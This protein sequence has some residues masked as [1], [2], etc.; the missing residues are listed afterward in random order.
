MNQFTGTSCS[1]TQL[2]YYF[3]NELVLRNVRVKNIFVKL[4]EHKYTL[5][6]IG[7]AN[8]SSLPSS[9]YEKPN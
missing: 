1:S 8:T 5:S 6:C 2:G 7:K 9:Q 4:L 3:F